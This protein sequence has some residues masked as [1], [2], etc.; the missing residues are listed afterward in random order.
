MESELGETVS[1]GRYRDK[2]IHG[3]ILR[4]LLWLGVPPLLNHIII[5]DYNTADAYWL[6]QYSDALVAVPDF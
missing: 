3:P 6:S 1:V 2:I 4:T 5:I